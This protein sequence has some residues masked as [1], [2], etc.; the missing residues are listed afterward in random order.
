MG[1]FEIYQSEKNEEYYFRLKAGNGEII[2]NSL[3]YNSKS[4]AE[5]GVESVRINSQTKERYVEKETSDK[6]Y[7]FN[8][9]AGNGQVIG[10]SLLYK[11]ESGMNNGIASVGKNA[12]DAEIEDLTTK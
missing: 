6:R 4:S 5:N 8:L 2:L 3:G 12:Y 1:K 10:S 9:K 11:S 7:Y